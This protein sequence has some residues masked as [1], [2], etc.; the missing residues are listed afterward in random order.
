MGLTYMARSRTCH[1]THHDYFRLGLPYTA[2][3]QEL[4]RKRSQLPVW[5]YREKFID[6]VNK[7]QVMVLVGETGSGKTTQVR[8]IC[9]AVVSLFEK[10]LFVDYSVNTQE[11]F[12]K[13]CNH[14]DLVIC[15]L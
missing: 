6:T 3:Y 14:S 12:T 15:G 1:I 11:I 9:D 10:E 13:F 5:D 4:F 7:N 2:R 8:K